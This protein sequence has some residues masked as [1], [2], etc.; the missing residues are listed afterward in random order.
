MAVPLVLVVCCALIMAPRLIAPRFGL[1][2]DGT[3][4]LIADAYEHNPLGVVNIEATRGRFRPVYWLYYIGQYPVWGKAPAGYFFVQLL[5]LI[6]TTLILSQIVL[7]LTHSYSA[8]FVAGAAFLISGPVIE[9]YYTLSK[10]EPPL[11]L[12]VAA[13]TLCVFRA[14]RSVGAQQRALVVAASLFTA[15][16]YLTKETAVVLLPVSLMFALVGWSRQQLR[17]TLLAFCTINIL[18]ALAFVASRFVT[19]TSAVSTGSDSS[20][21]VLSGPQLASSATDSVAWLIRDFAFVLPLLIAALLVTR[22]QP[23]R[24]GATLLLQYG[25]LLAGA[26]ILIMLPWRSSFEYYL[27]PVAFG[28][29]LVVGTSWALL[30]PAVRQRSLIAFVPVAASLL[31]ACVPIANEVTTAQLQ[32]SLDQ[33]NSDLAQALSRLTPP[34]GIAVTNLPQDSEYVFELGLQL[35]ELYGRNDVTVEGEDVAV[36][37]SPAVGTLVAVQHVEHRPV[38]MP[39]VATGSTRPASNT[40]LR[41]RNVWSSAAEVQ[42]GVVNVQEPFCRLVRALGAPTGEICQDPVLVVDRQ[43]FLYGWDVYGV[44]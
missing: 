13:A 30:R 7:Q 14:M 11:V 20:N 6:V 40:D 23:K 10:P 34:G 35:R 39:R 17:L 21:Y 28:L 9:A 24:A 36:A 42:L 32:L 37:T 22:R 31:L 3:T 8:G 4:L 25:V 12:F 41:L 5:A 44:G 26:W 15:L 29:A 2:D 1:L 19:G 38:L 43:P 16:A 18:C 33:T 27:L